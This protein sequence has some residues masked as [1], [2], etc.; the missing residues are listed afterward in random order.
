MAQIDRFAMKAN[1]FYRFMNVV[2]V[3]GK[4]GCAYEATTRSVSCSM[5]TL[6]PLQVVLV[7]VR[8]SKGMLQQLHW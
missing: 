6:Q 3:P 2:I 7:V 5:Q 1:S 8:C 4:S